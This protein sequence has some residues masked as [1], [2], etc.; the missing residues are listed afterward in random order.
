[1]RLRPL[2][3]IAIERRSRIARRIRRWRFLKTRD[4]RILERVCRAPR[5]RNGVVTVD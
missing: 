4:F 5:C 3:L 2:Y 1:M